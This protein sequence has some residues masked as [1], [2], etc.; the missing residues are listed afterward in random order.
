MKRLRTLLVA[1]AATALLSAL[2]I[3]AQ[4]EPVVDGRRIAVAQRACIRH[5][6][7]IVAAGGKLQRACTAE[8]RRGRRAIVVA[9][10]QHDPDFVAGPRR[11]LRAVAVV[12]EI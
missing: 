4:D 5:S 11:A 9:L 1:A 2:P 12:Q 10:G 3:A 6:R 8:C 7:R